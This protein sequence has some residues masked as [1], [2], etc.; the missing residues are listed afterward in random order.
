M[1]EQVLVVERSVKELIN[2]LK[3][4]SVVPCDEERFKE[5][6]LEEW[7]PEL[8]GQVACEQSKQML[9][10]DSAHTMIPWDKHDAPP[11]HIVA[12]FTEK[13]NARQDLTETKLKIIIESLDE[14]Q[15]KLSCLEN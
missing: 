13:L 6:L 7:L 1:C 11:A 15:R 10:Q 3:I 8:E 9:K 4:K 12:R 2:D 14:L 5:W